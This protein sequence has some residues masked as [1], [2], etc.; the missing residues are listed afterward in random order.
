MKHFSINH[1]LVRPHNLIIGVAAALVAAIMPMYADAVAAAASSSVTLSVTVGD[2]NAGKQNA[3]N[4]VN[5]GGTLL[6]TCQQPPS[7]TSLY[8]SCNITVPAD[9]GVLV[10]AQPAPGESLLG[11]VGSHCI[12]APG[13]V[14]HIQMGTANQ[15]VAAVFHTSTPGPVIA[16]TTY[17]ANGAPIAFGQSPQMAAFDFDNFPMTVNGSGFPHNTAATLTDDGTVVATSMT[18]GSGIVSFTYSPQSEPGVYRRLVA[19]AGGQTARTDAYNTLLYYYQQFTTGGGETYFKV[20]ET[21]M[22][23]QLDNFVQY[24][25]NP[26]VPMTFTTGSQAKGYAQIT[27]PDYACTPTGTL[28]LTGTKG[29]GTNDSFNYSVSIGAGC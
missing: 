11:F 6:G 22:D 20:T 29:K 18:D 12:T 21:D 17:G 3:V 8:T 23:N 1:H 24:N 26:T 5:T 2:L 28:M 13:P 27:T 9:K 16:A 10:I 7:T 15:T 25:S 4:V 19:S 14:C